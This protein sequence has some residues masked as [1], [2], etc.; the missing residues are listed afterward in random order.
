MTFYFYNSH[1]CVTVTEDRA[2]EIS[3]QFRKGKV[4]GIDNGSRTVLINSLQATHSQS[5]QPQLST[6]TLFQVRFK[7][8]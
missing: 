2:L 1:V 8:I 7:I 5:L 6:T 4:I 3:D